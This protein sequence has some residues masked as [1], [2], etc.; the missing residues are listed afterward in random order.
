MLIRQVGLFEVL[1]KADV[2]YILEFLRQ[3]L[4]TSCS[5]RPSTSPACGRSD[6]RHSTNPIFVPFF[7]IYVAKRT[8]LCDFHEF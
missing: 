4:T 2:V 3:R 6:N 1:T 5:S 8:G 7:V